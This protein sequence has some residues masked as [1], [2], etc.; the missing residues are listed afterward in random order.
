MHVFDPTT[1]LKFL[2]DTGSELSILPARSC[3]RKARVTSHLQAANGTLI[4]VYGTRLL[5]VT[6]SL[7]REFSWIFTVADV[8]TPLIGADFLYHFGLSVDFKSRKLRDSVT[9]L[10]TTADESDTPPLCFSLTPNTV[11]APYAVLLRRHASVTHAATIG[12]PVK[13]SVM[14]YIETTGPPVRARPRRLA[15]DRL[16]AAKAEF[17]HMMRLGIVEP[18]DSEFASPLHMV[19]KKDGDWRPCGDYRGLNSVTKPDRYPLPLLQ[20]F[21]SSLHGKTVFSKIDLTRAY[22]QIPINPSDR[23]KTAITT[24]FGLFQFTR[25]S[26]G[27]RNAAQTFQRFIDQVVRG[28]DFVFVYLDDAL[29]ASSSEEEHVRHVDALLARFAEYGV[30][31]N[32]AKCVFGA[33]ELD[34][35]GHHISSSGIRPLP[36]KIEALQVFPKPATPRQLRRYLGMVNFYHRFIPGCARLLRP[37]HALLS[38]SKRADAPLEWT[39]GADSAFEVSKKALSEAALLA[40]PCPEAEISVVTDASDAAVGAVLQ[41]RT[42]SGWQPLAFFS[43]S[44][45]PTEA[46]YSAFDRELLAIYLAIKHFRY[47]LEGR[48]FHVFTDHKPIIYALAARSDRYSPR[49]QRHL[50]FISEFTTDIR[51]VSGVDNVVA[52]A[53]SRGVNEIQFAGSTIDYSELAAAQRAESDGYAE[54]FD[55]VEVQLQFTDGTIFCDRS[56]GVNRPIV[57]LSFRRRI[58]DATH[59]LSHPGVRATLKL[60]AARFV[61]QGMNKDVREWAQSCLACQRSKVS[62]HTVSPLGSFALPSRRFRHVHIDIVILSYSGGFSY[63]LTLVDRFSRWPEAIPLSD[64]TASTVAQAFLDGWVARFGVP[65]TLTSDRG[66]Q[67]ESA[68]W[69]SLMRRLGIRHVRTTAYHPAANGMVERLH[70]QLKASL[71]AHGSTTTWRQALPLVLLGIRAAIKEDLGHSP[72]E[73]VYGEPLRLPG[74]FFA[75]D[76]ARPAI[77]PCDFVSGLSHLMRSL[78]AVPPRDADRPTYIPKSLES[79]TQ[80]FV[81]HD[82]VRRALQPPYDGPYDVLNRADKYYTL[83]IDGSPVNVCIDRLKPAFVSAESA[84]ASD[85]D[86]RTSPS[87]PAV[88]SSP[89]TMSPNSASSASTPNAMSPTSPSISS[90]WTPELLVSATPTHE[91]T[92]P[93]RHAHSPPTPLTPERQPSPATGTTRL[94]RRVRFPRHLADYCYF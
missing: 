93:P 49:Q 7:R 65:E 28:L 46:R 63:L 62:R 18:S 83:R 66:G 71:M 17:E 82:G 54:L 64:I 60:I 79:C 58:F 86:C 32:P 11:P 1:S 89:S 91:H 72:A 57:P 34:F 22:H 27:L 2:L 61:W 31:I 35:L 13:H 75:D 81:R 42:T 78:R 8:Q 69:Q 4:P 26:F 24:P 90:P 36:S 50:S 87:D 5:T 51:H 12:A 80:V 20:D 40:F 6:L 10:G 88:A 85:R 67:F 68:L 41:Q 43:K 37:L 39:A 48:V 29:C 59:S 45:T 44:L 38:V 73:F 15:P 56:T 25:M 70:R 52:D 23:H 19:P 77:E 16:K 9:S 30:V 74:E 92:L 55:V 94:G 47:F 14:H 84:D 53:L 33:A 76:A 21:A 3:D